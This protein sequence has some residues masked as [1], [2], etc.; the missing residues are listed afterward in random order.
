M[1]NN[2]K[3]IVPGAPPM[4][5]DIN[6]LIQMLNGLIDIGVLKFSSPVAAP[7]APTI[8]AV[9]GAANLTGT[10]KYKLVYLTGWVDSYYNL[11]VNGFSVSNETSIT[12]SS[13]NASIT[14]PSFPT[15]VIGVAIYRT[16]AGGASDTQKYVDIMVNS[17]LGPYVD[18]VSDANLGTRM[19]GA[20]TS[21]KAYGTAIPAS[22]PT[23]NTTGTFVQ[24]TNVTTSVPAGPSGTLAIVNGV[25]C[26]SNGSLWC[27]VGSAS[28]TSP[29]NWLD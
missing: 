5:T 14:I 10:Y 19:L 21:P 24:V 18:S 20:S 27:P 13:Q 3:T 8:S 17:A 29:N 2:L 11:Y 16:A 22:V 28:L 12:L 15:S 4:A 7:S 6:Q 1:A 9:A 25:L 23:T 26:A